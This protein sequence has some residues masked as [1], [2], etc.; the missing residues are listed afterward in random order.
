[1]F[2]YNVEKMTVRPECERWIESNRRQG[3]W[4]KTLKSRVPLRLVRNAISEQIFCSDHSNPCSPEFHNPCLQTQRLLFA[5]RSTTHVK[6]SR[7]RFTQNY[8]CDKKQYHWKLYWKQV[9]AGLVNE[10]PTRPQQSFLMR[11]KLESLLIV[12]VCFN[13]VFVTW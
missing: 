10:N 7:T 9:I 11:K 4:S 13:A 5:C 12:V 8:V 1:M 6:W 2:N 3:L